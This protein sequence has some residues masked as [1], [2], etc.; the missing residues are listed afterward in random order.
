MPVDHPPQICRTMEVTPGRAY[1]IEVEANEAKQLRS[2]VAPT[3][4]THL[5]LCVSE[6]RD[7]G[8]AAVITQLGHRSDEPGSAT[9]QRVRSSDVHLCRILITAAGRLQPEP[10][11]AK[12]FSRS[13]CPVW[14]LPV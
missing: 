3:G 1:T 2:F 7:Q 9:R 5:T 8:S 11:H 6:H 12:K 14:V 4:V 13:E 10:A